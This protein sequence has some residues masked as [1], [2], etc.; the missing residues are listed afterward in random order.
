[1]FLR[2]HLIRLIPYAYHQGDQA[3]S[4]AR[5][6]ETCCANA[7]HRARTATMATARVEVTHV[8][9]RKTCFLERRSSGAPK[10]PKKGR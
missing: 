1:M 5:H 8:V 3:G 9:G 10:A 2:A 4:D 7:T 6:P